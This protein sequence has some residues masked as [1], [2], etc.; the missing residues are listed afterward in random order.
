MALTLKLSR[1][2][3]NSLGTE[4]YIS[5]VTGIYGPENEG[6]WGSPNL[7]REQSNIFFEAYN[8]TSTGDKEIEIMPYD[9]ESAEHITLLT[10]QDGYIDV[11]AA[12]VPK[13]A[14]DS[15]GAWGTSNNRLVRM[16]SGE[17]VPK[18]VQEATEDVTLLTTVSF[19]TVLLARIAIA[20][21]RANIDLIK[22]RQSKN[23]DRAHNREIA[24]KENRFNYLR[25]LLDGARYLWCADNY[26][27]SQLL[28]ESFNE[29]I[30]EDE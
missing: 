24:D 16:E 26:I 29:I 11:L 2:S 13:I 21:N 28:V 17:L 18:T 15:E 22:L 9:P 5:D 14:P 6:G 23:D 4:M 19:K 27:K 30:T 1:T 10:T 25:G 12:V 20:R 3:I 7:M 8:R